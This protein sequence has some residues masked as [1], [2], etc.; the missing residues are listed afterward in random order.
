MTDLN[1]CEILKGHE[2][3]TFYSPTFGEL[4][5]T[6]FIGKTIR[7]ER[8]DGIDIILLHNG[9]WCKDSEEISVYPS[10]DQRDWNKWDDEN[11]SKVPKTFDDLDKSNLAK[12]LQ[13]KIRIEISYKDDSLCDASVAKSTIEKS[14]LAMLKLHQLIE[15]GYGGNADKTKEFYSITYDVEDK[16]F[17]V[18]RY[19]NIIYDNFIVCF[20]SE[21]LA[22]EFLLY[23]ENVELLKD[24]F[25]IDDNNS[26]N[27][28]TY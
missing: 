5:L 3:E 14:A 24:Y 8:K 6:D 2:G 1:L 17:I 27:K 9:K 13:A 16:R 25:M 7:F 18:R 28:R 11:N 4:T 22:E 10:K 21:E 15:V 12:Q 23:K 26:K 19:K 20:K